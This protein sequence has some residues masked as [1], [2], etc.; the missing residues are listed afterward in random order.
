MPTSPPPPLLYQTAAVTPLSP[1]ARL[2]HTIFGSPKNSPVRKGKF[3][4]AKAWL[5]SKRQRD[6]SST[7]AAPATP[8]K[9]GPWWQGRGETR[10]PP[11][12]YVAT[13][14]NRAE[15]TSPVSRVA[16]AVEVLRGGHSPLRGRANAGAWEKLHKR[17]VGT[18]E[19]YSL[20]CKV[21]TVYWTTDYLRY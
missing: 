8:P 14:T 7:P 12:T 11:T 2:T 16:H 18:S 19:G 20:Y 3:W 10:T 4:M 6:T 15:G 9:D 21:F 5:S 17:Y 13:N 1:R